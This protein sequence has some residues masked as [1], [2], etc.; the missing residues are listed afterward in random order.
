MSTVLVYMS[1]DAK[2]CLEVCGWKKFDDFAGGGGERGDSDF[3]GDGCGASGH[4]HKDVLKNQLIDKKI[5]DVNK[6]DLL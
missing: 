4:T 5:K 1:R 6:K 3:G 2:E